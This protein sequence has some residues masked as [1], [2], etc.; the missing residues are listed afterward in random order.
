MSGETVTEEAMSEGKSFHAPATGKAR[1]PTVES[2]TTGTDHGTLYNSY[3]I[4]YTG[5]HEQTD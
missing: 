2:L 3:Y 4:V 5:F 1:R